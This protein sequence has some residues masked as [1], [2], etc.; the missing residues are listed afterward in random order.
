[1]VRHGYQLDLRDLPGG[2]RIAGHRG[3]IPAAGLLLMGL[4]AGS[5]DEVGTDS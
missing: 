1:M 4:A 5:D 3:E 2:I